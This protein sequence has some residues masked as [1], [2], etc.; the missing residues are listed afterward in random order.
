MLALLPP[1]QA[2]RNHPVLTP[3]TLHHS[4]LARIAISPLD[5]LFRV[6]RKGHI[7]VVGDEVVEIG[8]RHLT[9]NWNYGYCEVERGLGVVMVKESRTARYGS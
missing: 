2:T 5:R 9:S 1:P 6:R 4:Q 7:H 3:M 8:T